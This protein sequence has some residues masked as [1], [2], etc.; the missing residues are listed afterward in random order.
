MSEA[1]FVPAGDRYEPTELTRGPW[2]PKAQHAGPPAALLGR[3]IERLPGDGE[4]M[5]G[6]ITFEIL[7]PIPMTPLIV[8]AEVKRPGRSVDF[9]GASLSDDQGEVVRASAWRLRTSD[10]ELPDVPLPDE[11]GLP[12][13][14]DPRY[15]PAPPSEAEP[16]EF[17]PTGYDTG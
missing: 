7:R 15:A 13:K 4:R 2:D 10:L 12:G 11:V 14:L 17:M 9:V 5:V 16:G 6:R 1:F 8:K 3:E